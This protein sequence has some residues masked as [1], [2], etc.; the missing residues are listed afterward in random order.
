MNF[1]NVGQIYSALADGKKI[2]MIDCHS[3][4][5]II[6]EDGHLKE[7]RNQNQK[8]LT[9][10][11]FV[12]ASHWEIYDGKPP[13]QDVPVVM[14]VKIDLRHNANYFVGVLLSV[15]KN[16][17]CVIID[18]YECSNSFPLSSVV[19]ISPHVPITKNGILKRQEP[20]KTPSIA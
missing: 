17:A 6:L 10:Q 20:E 2:R 11:A 9:S 1:Q 5:Y 18:G 7:C 14:R 16:D 19:E 13:Q 8:L 12:N 15:L 4:Y 3:G